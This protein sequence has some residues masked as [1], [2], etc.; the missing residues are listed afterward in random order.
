MWEMIE[1][2]P[3]GPPHGQYIVA[4]ALTE[5]DM[6]AENHTHWRDPVT[7]TEVVVAWH[8]AGERPQ[9]NCQVRRPGVD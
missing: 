3:L 9:P 2:Q 8:K 6:H 4:C 1:C 5:G 7:G